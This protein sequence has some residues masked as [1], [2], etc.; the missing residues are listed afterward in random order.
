MSYYV[1]DIPGRLR[2]KIPAVK[3]NAHLAAEVLGLLKTL[4]GVSSVTP[5]TITGSI[6]ILYDPDTV[7][8]A[9]ILDLLVREGH[10]DVSR[11]VT[12]DEYIKSAFDKAGKAVSRALLNVFMEKAFEGSALSYL[13]VLI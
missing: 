10:F 8:S 4:C 6:V 1:H 5:S 12:T 3:G 2:V 9:R 13:T 11:A 7:S